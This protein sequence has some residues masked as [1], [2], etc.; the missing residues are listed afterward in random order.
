MGNH[1]VPADAVAA[2]VEEEA[3]AAALLV[4]MVLKLSAASGSQRP[5]SPPHLQAQPLSPQA[6][7]A[8]GATAVRQVQRSGERAAGPCRQSPRLSQ[9][10]LRRL[11]HEGE[12]QGPPWRLRRSMPGAAPVIEVV[13]LVVEAAGPAA[14]VAAEAAEAAEGVAAVRAVVVAA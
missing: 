7:N 10:P 13:V 9:R 5:V 2:A 12:R 11:P 3:V 6:L 14:P 1:R 8:G 4:S